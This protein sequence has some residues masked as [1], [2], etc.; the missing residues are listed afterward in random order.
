MT[1]KKFLFIFLLASLIW[2][3]SRDTSSED[4]ER[5]AIQARHSDI[6]REL[7][8]SNRLVLATMS[9]TKTITTDDSK[10]WG[11][12]I[13]VYSYDTHLRATVDLTKLT[14]DDLIFDDATKT[15]TVNL[16]PIDID[17]SG[18]DMT[19][20]E[21][22]TNIG[23]LRTRFDSKERAEAKEIANRDLKR[24]LKS[25]SS[26]SRILT[27]R[28]ESKAREYLKSFFEANGYS[29]VI[30]FRRPLFIYNSKL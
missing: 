28:A 22:Y 4:A 2:G 8:G 3:C 14:P 27:D 17:L 23:L 9:V 7:T 19:L 5:V 10:L 30:N 1:D 18:R 24:E 13:G 20:R 6:Y 16:P 21:E 26:F 15:V 12:K 25:D 29:A 11:K